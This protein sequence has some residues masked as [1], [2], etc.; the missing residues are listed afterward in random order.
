M[1]KA[2]KT[3][4]VLIGFGAMGQALY[5]QW[6][7]MTPVIADQILILEPF[8]RPSHDL[9]IGVGQPTT[10]RTLHGP[11]W[12]TDLAHTIGPDQRL[13]A[14]LATKPQ[15]L[16][17]VAVANAGLLADPRLACVLSIMAGVSTQRLQALWPARTHAPA[18]IRAMPNLPAQI[19]QGMTVLCTPPATKDTDRGYAT[20]LMQAVG[21][22]LWLEDETMM[23]AVTALSGS[24]PAY[25]CALVEAMSQA[26]TALGLS[27]TT[28]Q[29]LARQTVIG[30]AALLAH[31]GAIGP[32]ELR[33]QVTS[34]GGTTEAALAVLH[35]LPE[36]RLAALMTTAMQAAA[37]RSIALQSAD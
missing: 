34:K 21:E 11:Q 25:V 30:T 27:A 37:E 8:W 7:R 35:A 19:G 36:S 17:Q 13:V 1:S 22:V 23:H 5:R 14:I 18:I 10:T 26:G 6:V 28:A 12:H 16:A 2:P 24:G 32:D 31:Q 15:S 29:T 33:H 3:T 9:V 20:R 4:L